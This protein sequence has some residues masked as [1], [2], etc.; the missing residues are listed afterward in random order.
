MFF[1]RPEQLPDWSAAVKHLRRDTVMRRLIARVGPCALSPRG[2]AFISL[3]QSIY[4]QQIST[5][6]ATTLYGRFA[7]K[8]PRRVPTPARVVE[9]LSGGWSEEEIRRC[10]LSR[11]KRVYVL[12][13]AEHFSRRKVNLRHLAQAD[14]ERVI[15][16]LTAVKGVGRWTAEMFLIFTLNRPDVLPVDDLGIREA[17]RRFYRLNDRPRADELRAIGEPWRPWRTVATW[18]LWRAAGMAEDKPT[19]PSTGKATKSR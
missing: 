2:D 4:A 14:D 16:A 3:V 7:D 5:K 10:G 18:Y 13:L 8:F 9:A 1:E 17:V 11:Q 6:I 15:E 19:R 12:D